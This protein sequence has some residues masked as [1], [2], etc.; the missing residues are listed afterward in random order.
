ME[1]LPNRIGFLVKTWPKLSE[2][3]I[4]E[5]VLGLE[6]LGQP[7]AIFALNP[8]GDE[9]R[10]DAVQ[11]VRAPVSYLSP[12]PGG[13]GAELACHL[14]LLCAAPWR[15]LAAVA[16]TARRP[17]PGRMNDFLRGARLAAALRRHGISHLHA[18]FVSEPAAVAEIGAAIAGL[19]YSLSAH[20]KDIY[21]SAPAVLAR[22]LAGARFTVTCTEYNRHHLAEIAPR[23][24]L[25]RMYH[26]IDLERFHP[27]LRQ[28]TADLPLILGVGRLREKK[29]FATLI[30]ACARLRD[31]GRPFRCEIIGY[32][33]EA[34]ALARR[35]SDNDLDGRVILAGKLA[36]DQV[37]ERYARASVFVLPSQLASDGDRDGIPNVLLEAMAMQVPVVSTPVSGIPELV[38]SGRNGVLVEPGDARG[39]ADAIVALTSN[40]GLCHRLG[41]AARRTVADCFDNERNLLLLRDALKSCRSPAPGPGR[42]TLR[43]GAAHAR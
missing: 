6:R 40:P 27:R 36:R 19:G 26:G 32:G 35:I 30:D 12:P 42:R 34:G 4:L 7:L 20:A 25:L 41:T 31:A 17:E 8:S 21:L 5:E 18:H 13:L 38:Q 29:G 23:A 37:I 16:R 39:F 11:R 28:P 1:T 10:H 22:K 43:S 3:F 15:Y 14:R 2:T 24:R 33:E 9:L